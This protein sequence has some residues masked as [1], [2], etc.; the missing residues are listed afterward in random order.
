M[1]LHAAKL[2]SEFTNAQNGR[3]TRKRE[4]DGCLHWGVICRVAEE[5]GP[6]AADVLMESVWL[7]SSGS[8]IPHTWVEVYADGRKHAFA[9]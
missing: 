7:R 2:V 3:K 9:V 5:D 4:G 6:R 8:V 1:H